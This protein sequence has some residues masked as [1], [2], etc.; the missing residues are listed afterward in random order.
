MPDKSINID[1]SNKIMI[2]PRGNRGKS[3]QFNPMFEVIIAQ[4]DKKQARKLEQ[5]MKIKNDDKRK[6][7]L[8][9]FIRKSYER[10]MK[11]A[12]NK[13]PQIIHIKKDEEIGVYL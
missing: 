2:D 8:L 7:K 5:I 9:K 13:H 11:N 10:R 4:R 6:S 12:V 1:Y 3:I